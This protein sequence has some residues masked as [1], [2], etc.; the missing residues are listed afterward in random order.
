MCETS[1]ERSSRQHHKSSSCETHVLLPD[2]HEDYL[3]NGC[4]ESALPEEDYQR[5][6]KA[7]RGCDLMMVLG[8]SLRITPACDLPG[9]ALSHGAKLAIINLQCTQLD[10]V[11]RI[12][13]NEREVPM[14]RF[15]DVV[16]DICP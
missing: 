14:Q 5:A 2:R 16:R 8:S 6:L 3:K 10:K 7:A 9:E 4:R 13:M 15:H 1:E 12:L 11:K